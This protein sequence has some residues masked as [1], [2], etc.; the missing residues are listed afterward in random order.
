MTD[1][2]QHM[3]RCL[4]LAERGFGSVAPNPMVGC[5]IVHEGKRIAE[6]W[7]R[8]FGG[9]HAEVDAISRVENPEL[10]AHA[11]LY[12]NLEPCSHHG[13]TPPCADLIAEKQIP[14]VVLAMQDPNPLVAGK[15]IAKLLHHGIDVK[16]GVEEEA[17]QFLNR[18][19]ITFFTKKRPYIILKWAQSSDG[20][21]DHVRSAENNGPAGISS[22]ESLVLSHKWRSQEAVILVGT[23][24]V[25]A[26]NPQLTVRR[27]EGRNPVRVTFDRRGRIPPEAKILDG[28]APTIVFNAD[29][30]Y[31]TEWAEYV[32]IDF[33]ESPLHQA[34]AELYHRNF[35]SVLVEGGA[36]ILDQFIRAGLWDEARVFCSEETLGSGVAAP[37][38]NFPL[39]DEYRSGRDTVKIY[40]NK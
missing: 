11:T 4:E 33:D 12:V 20:F 35:Q 22:E 25:L 5:V 10:L 8:Q 7:H 2:I 1:H 16:I 40:Y 13:K 38:F 39:G 17:A 14:Y 19:F 34:L 6:G 3:K 29:K 15:G 18:R 31:T 23:N 32:R 24:T 36:A 37:A 27:T 21:I 28:I 26:D 30:N 9:P